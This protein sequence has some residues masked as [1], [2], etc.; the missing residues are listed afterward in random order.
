MKNLILPV[1]ILLIFAG[2]DSKQAQQQT[3][4]EQNQTDEYA[5]LDPCQ[6][7]DKVDREM[8]DLYN[9]VMEKYADDF[10]FINWFK[11]SQIYWVQYKD[12]YVKSLYP[13]KNDYYKK[14]FGK[15]AGYCKCEEWTRMTRRRI[16]DI[17][18]FLGEGSER[19][20]HCPTSIKF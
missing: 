7:L 18:V 20:K 1:F 2:C 19:Y 16:E 9:E 8:L 3:A 10:D 5:G 4:K 12:R 14:E 15:D 6:V 11:Q 17:K 13:R